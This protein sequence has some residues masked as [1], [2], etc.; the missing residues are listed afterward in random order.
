M[1]AAILAGGLGTRLRPLTETIPK[2]MVPVEG[3]PFL[4]HLLDMLKKQGIRDIVL[5]IGHLGQKVKDYFG[6]GQ[7]LGLHIGYSEERDRLLGT[8]G[9]L[10]QARGLLDEHFLVVNG[11]T[12]LPLDYSELERAFTCRPRKVLMA[13]YDNQEDTGVPN[14]IAL[15][16]DGLVLRYNRKE[17][18]PGLKHVEAGVLIMESEVLDLIEAK[19]PV[20]LE[21]GLYPALIEQGE[22]AAYVVEQRFYDIGTPEQRAVFAEY[23]RSEAA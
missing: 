13:V 10:K 8:G 20:S 7:R 6:D 15:D 22:L 4:L 14:N 18:S 19:R 9:A 1:Q 17:A 21:E 5:C 3:Q 16:D 11:D 2:V 12:Y 23:L